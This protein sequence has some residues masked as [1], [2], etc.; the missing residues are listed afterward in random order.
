MSTKRIIAR[1]WLY[2]LGFVLGAVLVI[3]LAYLTLIPSKPEYVRLTPLPEMFNDGGAQTVDAY[4]VVEGYLTEAEKDSID[5]LCV[6]L[7]HPTVPYYFYFRCA[8]AR[9]ERE[10]RVYN[11]GVALVDG[12]GQV[13]L[14]F[15]YPLFL[16][17][18]S[19]I[20][21]VRQVKKQ[22]V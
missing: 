20:W 6:E 19:I 2:I 5:A 17:I 12:I 22:P 18:R 11:E 10:Q 3:T 9:M 13:V 21:A 15:P 16:I 14:Y 1:E 8:E 4:K 7:G